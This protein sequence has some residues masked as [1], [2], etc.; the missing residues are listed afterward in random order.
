M[1]MVM[2]LAPKNVLNSI[3]NQF[4]LRINLNIERMDSKK[5]SNIFKFLI[6]NILIA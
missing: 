4:K 1:L 3:I 5:P 2:N 6:I